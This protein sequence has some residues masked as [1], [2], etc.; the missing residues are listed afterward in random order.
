MR[1]VRQHD[2]LPIQNIDFKKNASEYFRHSKLLPNSIRAIIVGPS[3]CGKTNVLISLL[4]HH[5]GLKFE[6]IYVFSKSLYQP[7][8]EYLKK[9][10]SPIKEIGY[11]TF[12]DNDAVLPLEEAKRNSVFVFDDILC[13]KQ[14]HMRSYF[15]M[16]R[17]K[18]I[19]SFYLGQTYTR[20]PKHLIRDN[21]NFLVIFKQDSL[22]LKH[23]YDDH[24]NTDMRF[25]KFRQVCSECW[26]D[27]Y[28]FLFINKDCTLENGRYRKGF[29]TFILI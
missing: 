20:I 5:N 29:D 11:Y 8:Y 3:N 17:H 23:V 28:G 22:N 27:N 9:L 18:N 19:D 2:Q 24:V 21:A 4:E 15:C 1:L 7:K 25:E 26:K 16:G 14:D 12:S 6:N 10:L 13:E